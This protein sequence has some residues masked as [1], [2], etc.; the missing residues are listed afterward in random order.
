M[1]NSSVARFPGTLKM[2]AFAWSFLRYD[3]TFTTC[4]MA[5][6]L[7]HGFDCLVFMKVWGVIRANPGKC[8]NC[9]I[10]YVFD[11]CT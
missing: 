8:Y 11:G 10:S 4:L 7:T 6:K 3:D 1:T 2:Q 9:N 5:Q